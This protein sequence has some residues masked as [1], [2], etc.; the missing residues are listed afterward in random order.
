[1]L[2]EDEVSECSVWDFGSEY[3]IS[4]ELRGG[5]WY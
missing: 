5:G 4:T 1:M 3:A 2:S